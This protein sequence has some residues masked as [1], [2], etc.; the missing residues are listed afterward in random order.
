MCIDINVHCINECVSNILGQCIGEAC[1]V[2]N[3]VPFNYKFKKSKKWWM[4][5]QIGKIMVKDELIA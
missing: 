3:R 4:H 5:L 2:G 1:K